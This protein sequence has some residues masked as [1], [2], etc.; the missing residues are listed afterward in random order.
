MKK[1]RGLRLESISNSIFIITLLAFSGNYLST[2]APTL[3]ADTAKFDRRSTKS[4]H[5]NVASYKPL[6]GGVKLSVTLPPTSL[7]LKTGAVFKKEN[8]P[9]TPKVTDW[10]LIPPWFAGQWHRE[11]ISKLFP[12]EILGD[13]FRLHKTYMERADHTW[14]HQIDRLGGIW[15]H[16]VE[17][18]AQM[19]ENDGIISRKTV[20]L[21]EPVMVSDAK[22]IM[23]YKD[24]TVQYKTNDN[25]IFR[26]YRHEQI[27]EIEHLGNLMVEHIRAK[28]FDENGKVSSEDYTRTTY[29]QTKPFQPIDF[30]KN[31]KL[32]LKED[33]KLYLKTH[34]FT[35][36]IPMPNQ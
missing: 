28:N 24:I 15:H 16:R 31:T 18:Y 5:G 14:G 35:D 34:G 8:I 36:R 26:T 7:T 12:I 3:R 25:T 10:Y 32:N 19:V 21:Q 6:Q 33:F 9:K 11:T 23:H 1:R 22:V 20:T 13:I 4:L 17:P 2:A 27:S 29:I 30:D